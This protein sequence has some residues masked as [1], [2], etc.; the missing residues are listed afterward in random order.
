MSK[1]RLEAFSD[2]V[3]AVAITL[4]VFNVQV[5]HVRA[6]D[7]TRALL[8][9]WPAYTSYAV[10]FLTIGI[11]WVNHHAVFH[12]IRR[13]D[14][15]LLFLNLFLL[16]SVAFIPFPTALLAEYV[17]SGSGSQAAAVV[18]SLTMTVMGFL[19]GALWTYAVHH[20]KLLVVNLDLDEARASIPR[21]AIGSGIYVLSIGVA[22][23]S[24]PVCLALYALTAIY[25]VFNQVPLP[26]RHDDG[27]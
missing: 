26:I 3:F 14:R 20:E 16:M 11:I 19:F 2:G 5:P 21:F 23:I 17:Q 24:A 15:P 1:G 6:V 8:D 13:V 9:Q 7:L 12:L 4:L 10:S 18:Y 22:F 25:Y 27:D